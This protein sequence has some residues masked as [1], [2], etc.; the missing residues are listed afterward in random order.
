VVDHRLEPLLGWLR[1]GSPDPGDG[2][3]AANQSHA[4]DECGRVGL[5]VAHAGQRHPVQSLSE[6]AL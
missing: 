4:D 2:V 3:Q 5:S 1:L 6:A